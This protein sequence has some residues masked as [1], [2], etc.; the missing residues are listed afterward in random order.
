MEGDS[1]S[2]EK[3]PLKIE[4]YKEQLVAEVLET[5][6]EENHLKYAELRARSVRQHF[7]RLAYAISDVII[8]IN[9][10]SLANAGYS[11]FVKEFSC[12]ATEG[13]DQVPAP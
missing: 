7:P 12:F 6:N 2:T 4:D 10:T 8:H 1:A 11:K 9:E 13:L 5:Y 3:L